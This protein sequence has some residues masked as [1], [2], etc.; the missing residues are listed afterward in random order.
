MRS[1]HEDDNDDDDDDDPDCDPETEDCTEEFDFD[2][3]ESDK[4]YSRYE[5][6]FLFDPYAGVS[7]TGA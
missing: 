5:K 7:K 1:S 2:A 3:T 4:I 6:E